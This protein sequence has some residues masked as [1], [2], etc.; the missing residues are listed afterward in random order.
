MFFL[1]KFMNHLK[2]AQ[3]FGVRIFHLTILILV[4]IQIINSN[5][6]GFSDSGAVSASFVEFYGTWLHMLTGLL[7][8]FLALL[9]LIIVFKQRG[10][11][12]Y[13]SWLTGNFSI[14]KSDMNQLRRFELPESK[15]YGLA[16]TV[17]GLGLISLLLTVISGGLWF[18]LWSYDLSWSGNA[19]EV[20]KFIVGLLQAY[21]VGHA[22][23][24]FLHIFL[25]EK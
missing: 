10:V 2:E 15:P 19:K 3:S 25:K 18:Y 17:Q 4:I 9:F 12:Y 24:S 21:I 22:S 1:N 5:F 16:A 23:M 6:M 11:G 13:F 20:H 8:T 14:L 7:I